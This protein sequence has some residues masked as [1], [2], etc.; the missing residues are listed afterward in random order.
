MLI[1][2][3]ARINL[4]C[5]LRVRAL[6]LAA[7]NGS[8][9]AVKTLLHLGAS[10]DAADSFGRT[11]LHYA[12]R[13]G[14]VAAAEVLLAAGSDVNAQDRA[15]ATPLA[16]AAR[17]GHAAVVEVLLR[18]G[19]NPGLEDL[20]GCTPSGTAINKHHYTTAAVFRSSFPVALPSEPD[21]NDSISGAGTPTGLGDSEGAG[22]DQD[23]W[24]DRLG[25]AAMQR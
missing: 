20:W 14:Q 8:S 21:R 19:G 22:D 15:G 6:H 25:P 9:K 1:D 2:A 10:C 16:A 3:G 12:A 5:N 23:F 17:G 18:H 24:G 4:P 11:P 13:A 7:L